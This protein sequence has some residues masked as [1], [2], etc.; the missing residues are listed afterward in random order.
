MKIVTYNVNG[1]RSRISQFGSLHKLLT[2][3]DADIICLQ[4]T[5]LRR[6]ELT[7]DLAMADGY[8]SYYSCT[9]TVDKGR[10]GYAGVATFC[11]VKSAFS[12]HEVALPIAAEEGFTGLLENSLNGKGEAHEGLGDFT[13][14]DLLK[15]DNE[16]RCVVTDHG[17]FVLFNLYGPRA[18]CDDAQRIQFKLTFYKILQKRWESLLLQGRRIIVVGDLN[19]APTALDRCDAGPDFEKNEFR[20]WFRSILVECR[21]PFNDVFR[22]KHPDRKEA[23]TCWPQNTGAEEFNYGSRI[24][25]ILC[26]GSCLHQEHDLQGHS[27]MNC[28]VMECDILTQYRRWKPG[29]TLR[30]KGGRSI[31][32]EG[33]D[34]APVLTR[35]LGIPDIAH[36]STPTLSARYIPMIRGLQQTLVSVLMKRQVAEQSKSFE[37]SGSISDENI[38]IEMGNERVKRSFENCSTSGVSHVESCPSNLESEGSEHSQSAP[39]NGTKKKARKNQ[40]QEDIPQSDYHSSD[41]PVVDVQSSSSQQDELNS[42]ASTQDRCELNSCSLEKEKTNVALLEWRRIQQV[43]QNSIPLCKGHSEPCVARVVK[44]QGPNFGRR[45]YVCARAEGPASNSEANCGYFKW[46]DS[47]SRHK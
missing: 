21:G 34:H 32:L 44:K 39:S 20:R 7:A 6:Q 37:M 2:S 30:W 23:F 10:T 43:M 22:T 26:A 42:S 18:E 47:K 4:E 13:K 28:H 1:L 36:H 29:N 25:H 12:S 40:C 38:R 45:F 3:F 17:H 15:V 41:T 14:D 19:I 5:K 33:S 31:K 46:A 8:E 16:G 35:L 11:R 9:R 24:D 27:F